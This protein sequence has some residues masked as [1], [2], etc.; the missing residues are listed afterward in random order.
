MSQTPQNSDRSAQLARA[1]SEAPFSSASFDSDAL[2]HIRSLAQSLEVEKARL[3]HANMQG[4]L[5]RL[6]HESAQA[7]KEAV[8][9][10]EIAASSL[11]KLLAPL[12][13]FPEIA[14]I[15]IQY[16]YQVKPEPIREDRLVI[17]YKRSKLELD[18][19][20]L[21]K[22]PS[23][24]VEM[25]RSGPE[26]HLRILM[27]HKRQKL[28]ME[29]LHSLVPN[30]RFLSRAEAKD[31]DFSET[32]LVIAFGGDNHFQYVAQ[33][34]NGETRILGLNSDPMTSHGALLELTPEKLEAAWQALKIGA[35]EIEPWTRLD[36]YQGERLLGRACCEVLVSEFARRD[37]SRYNIEIQ[38]GSIEQKSSGLLIATGSGSSGWYESAGADLA[39]PTRAFERT[40]PLAKFLSTEHSR[41]KTNCQPGAACVMPAVVTRGII[42]PDRPMLISSLNDSAGKIS[43]DSLD[44]IRFERGSS[45]RIQISKEPL[46]SVVF[47]RA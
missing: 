24:I 10:L 43:L 28:A 47:P 45:V 39:V 1:E 4:A 19:E 36:V 20:R 25:Y 31:F 2:A 40:A 8:Q 38:N 6:S 30:A 29:Q 3:S 22:A 16:D 11:H 14:D 18:A 46:W 5:A 26:D 37:M 34:L 9:G 15:P 33:F 17:V 35:Y 41:S 23:E 32:D 21:Q 7:I 42:Q 27:S 44:D 12:E 13:T